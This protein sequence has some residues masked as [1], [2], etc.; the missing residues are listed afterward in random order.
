MGNRSS[1]DYP[2]RRSMGIAP[3]L[4]DS[5]NDRRVEAAKRRRA[6]APA[7]DSNPARRFPMADVTTPGN[8]LSHQQRH[9]NVE[10]SNDV[11]WYDRIL[12]LA[13]GR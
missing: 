6:M 13:R 3:P 2:R 4:K 9:Q 11:C 1:H 12:R 5:R 7:G 8:A 10:K